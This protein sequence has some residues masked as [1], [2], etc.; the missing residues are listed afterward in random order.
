MNCN[1]SIENSFTKW[2]ESYFEGHDIANK[3]VALGVSGGVDSMVLL[4]LCLLSSKSGLMPKPLV[5]HCNHQLRGDDSEKD[6]QLVADYCESHSIEHHISLLDVRTHQKTNKL[7]I[8]ESAR[9]LRYKA[10]IQSMEQFSMDHLL[11]GHHREDQIETFFLRLFRGTGLPGLACM[12]I[13]DPFP[14]AS[15]GLRVLRPFIDHNKSEILEYAHR[16]QIPF[17]NDQSNFQNDFTRNRIRNQWIPSINQIM[18]QRNWQK[19]IIDLIDIAS[20]SSEVIEMAAHQWL[21]S[22]SWNEI[23][24]FQELPQAIKRQVILTQLKALGLPHRFDT[25]TQILSTPRTW[26]SLSDQIEVYLSSDGDLKSRNDQLSSEPYFTSSNKLDFRIDSL[27]EAPISIEF[28]GCITEWSIISRESVNLKQ[29]PENVEYLDLKAVGKSIFLRHW[30]SGDVFQP[31]GYQSPFKLKKWFSSQKC[32]KPV[33]HHIILAESELGGI[34]WV[35]SGRIAEWS[36]VIDPKSPI[37]CLKW[38]RLD[39]VPVTS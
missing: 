38:S 5:L 20:T 4:Q 32:P 37:L 17:H 10:F 23:T 24:E 7:S 28:G 6:A 34:F 31:L 14:F 22:K 15:N 2:A 36:K 11:L 18:G 9:I 3:K 30:Q 13:D 33:R 29:K 25:V 16:H 8:E 35:E 19:S 26:I 1:A 39:E 21:H 12:S 27:T